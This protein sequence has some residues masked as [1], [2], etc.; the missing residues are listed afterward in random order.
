M[1]TQQAAGSV[2]SGEQDPGC[3]REHDGGA[4]ED[5]DAEVFP[6]GRSSGHVGDDDETTDG[7]FPGAT[8]F[9]VLSQTQALP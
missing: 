3:R 6:E 5:A 1:V 9:A 8:E 4:C 7:K 2:E